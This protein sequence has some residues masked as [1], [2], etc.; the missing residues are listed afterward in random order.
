[1]RWALTVL[2][3][4]HHFCRVQ[5]FLS[6]FFEIAAI[7]W[8]AMMMYVL[9][10]IS[11]M[12][13][14]KTYSPESSFSAYLTVTW[15]AAFILAIIPLTFGK[16]ERQERER[17]A[18]KRG[19]TLVCLNSRCSS[20]AGGYGHMGDAGCWIKK[21]NFQLIWYIPCWIALCFVTTSSYIVRVKVRRF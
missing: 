16:W 13:P 8:A 6:S 3:L 11:F 18:S 12:S 15:T 4:S 20:L 9:L 19:G 14:T 7:M 10:R 1:M 5:A 2:T 21:I 17:E